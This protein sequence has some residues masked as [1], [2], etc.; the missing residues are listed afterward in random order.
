MA[1]ART[2][3]LVHAQIEPSDR[4]VTDAPDERKIFAIV[5]PEEQVEAGSHQ[6][7]PL[8]VHSQGDGVVASRECTEVLGLARLPAKDVHAWN[9]LPLVTS[10][11]HA[12]VVADRSHGRAHYRRRAD[13]HLQVAHPVRLVPNEAR[14]THDDAAVRIDGRRLFVPAVTEARHPGITRPAEALKALFLFLNAYD[15]GAVPAH[16][17][18][19]SG[20]LQ[21]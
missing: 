13:R 14:V 11:D 8:C 7:S 18:R 17:C 21:R 4:G 6:L 1:P 10:G 19:R 2:P 3:I 5:V 16:G 20:H 9:V 15:H 12:A